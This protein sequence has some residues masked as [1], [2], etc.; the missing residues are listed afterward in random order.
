MHFTKHINKSLW[1][2]TTETS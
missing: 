2:R 1:Y